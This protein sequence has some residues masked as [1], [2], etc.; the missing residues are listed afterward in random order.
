MKLAGFLRE[1][2]GNGPQEAKSVRK[3]TRDAGIADRTL[4]RAK[5]SLGVQAKKDG[6]NGPWR[7]HFEERHPH[8]PG[9][10]LR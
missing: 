6:L 8:R 2:L 1:E 10:V 5:K 7:W 3:A 9:G 4:D